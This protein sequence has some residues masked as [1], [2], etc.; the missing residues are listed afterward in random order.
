MILNPITIVGI[1]DTKNNFQ[2]WSVPKQIGGRENRH[3]FPKSWRGLSEELLQC[4]TGVKDALF[5]HNKGFA[6]SAKTLEGTKQL[7]NLSL[8]QVGKE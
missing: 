6:V 8:R 2:A 4:M 7:V 5:C 1:N 3:Y